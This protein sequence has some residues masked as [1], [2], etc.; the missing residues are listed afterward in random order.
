MK[1]KNS[2]MQENLKLLKKSEV[3]V[4]DFTENVHELTADKFE[5]DENS[6]LQMFNEEDKNEAEVY[7]IQIIFYEINEQICESEKVVYEIKYTLWKNK[8][9][10]HNVV[11]TLMKTLKSKK[12][13]ENA[14]ICKLRLKIQL[15]EQEHLNLQFCA[16]IKHDHSEFINLKIDC[17]VK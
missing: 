10:L 12:F 3:S 5:S 9:S 15:T 11:N 16:Q 1:S 6:T 7:K 14:V 17:E 8:E 13:S 4:S 2:V